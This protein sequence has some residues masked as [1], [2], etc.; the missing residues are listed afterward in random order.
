MRKMKPA[1][2]MAKPIKAAAGKMRPGKMRNALPN[3]GPDTPGKMSTKQ[4]EDK[5]GDEPM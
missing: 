4:F 3:K 1:G 2:K 5:F